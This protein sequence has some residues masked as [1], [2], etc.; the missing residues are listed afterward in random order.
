MTT[1][2]EET[3]LGSDGEESLVHNHTNSL[4]TNSSN[5]YHVSENGLLGLTLLL[6]EDLEEQGSESDGNDAESVIDQF[7]LDKK[8]QQFVAFNRQL[9]SFIIKQVKRP[10]RG[11]SGN[12]L[13]FFFL[14]PDTPF[15]FDF[16][17]CYFYKYLIYK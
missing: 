16:S 13:S 1:S 11:K 15:S 4:N 10:G 7:I 8:D 6:E 3:A 5:N 2:D 14:F 12:P 17:S 9:K